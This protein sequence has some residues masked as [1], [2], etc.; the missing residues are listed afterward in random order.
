MQY[1]SNYPYMVPQNPVD[2]YSYPQNLYTAFQLIK[3]SVV[4]EYEDS[5]F[6]NYLISIAPT[7][8]DKNIITG[9]R[10]DEIKH[11]GLFREIYYELTGQMLPQPRNGEFTKPAS[12]CQGL[13][14]ALLG[15]VAAV[16]RYRRILYALQ[17][18]RQINMLTEII[19]DEI[20]HAS[21]YNFLYSKN[22]CYE[23]EKEGEKED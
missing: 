21:L 15:E 10:D 8:E 12:Y 20:R 9:I 13:K 17:D 14:K 19:T 2:P 3:E 5:M 6:Y 1:Y 23:E 11:A 7:Q 16:E 18:R 4:D 22:E